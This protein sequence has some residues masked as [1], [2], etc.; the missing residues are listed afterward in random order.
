MCL[1]EHKQSF[2]EDPSPAAER[3]IFWNMANG[4]QLYIREQLCSSS[5]ELTNEVKS[6]PNSQD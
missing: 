3:T 1:N 2:G 4:L 6:W 5:R